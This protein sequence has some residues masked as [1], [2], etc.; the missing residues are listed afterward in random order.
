MKKHYSAGNHFW[1]HITYVSGDA[2]TFY[3]LPHL[4]IS[5]YEVSIG[6]LFFLMRIT[7]KKDV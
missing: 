5:D 4:E 1:F 2:W 7:Y 6:W 3:I